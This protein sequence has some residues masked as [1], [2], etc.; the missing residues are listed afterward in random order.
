[1]PGSRHGPVPLSTVGS[2]PFKVSLELSLT[3]L[4]LTKD[5]L[6]RGGGKLLSSAIWNGAKM[7]LLQMGS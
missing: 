7:Y 3:S 1:M 4:S 6:P 5:I 2:R